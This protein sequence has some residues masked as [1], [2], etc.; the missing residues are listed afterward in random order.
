[1]VMWVKMRIAVLLLTLAV[2]LRFA[3]GSRAVGAEGGSS[4]LDAPLMPWNVAGASVL[5]APQFEIPVQ[6]VCAARERAAAGGEEAQL[7]ST[8]WRLI[9]AWPAR[10]VSVSYGAR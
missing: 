8:G 4:W 10:R 6:P 7:T 3:V 9:D 1:M 5:P 2:I